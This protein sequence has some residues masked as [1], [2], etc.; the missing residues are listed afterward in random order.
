MVEGERARAAE[1]EHMLGYAGGYGDPQDDGVEADLKAELE[2]LQA[3]V[4]ER[5]DAIQELRDGFASADERRA[6]LERV[7]ADLRAEAARKIDP[8]DMKARVAALE[9]QA[10][11]AEELERRAA[12]LEQ[13]ITALQAGGGAAD[14]AG[15]AALEQQVAE[16]KTALEQATAETDAGDHEARVCSSSRSWPRRARPC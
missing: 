15:R 14:D 2:A 4:N 7:L 10:K 11:H 6:E 3:Q 8:D 16:L 1:L 9:K 13:Q 5:E 12:E